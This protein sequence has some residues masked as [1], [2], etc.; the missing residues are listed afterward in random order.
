M[1]DHHVEDLVV[2]HKN[3]ARYLIENFMIAAN[4]TMVHFLGKHGVPHI[5]RIV[6]T[7][8]RWPRICQVAAQH[9]YSLPT[10]PDAP[11]L[12]E[13]LLQQKLKNP[14]QFPDIS[15]TIVKL[16]GR[17]EYVLAEPGKEKDGHF[18]L[19]VQDYTHSTAPNR[20]Y[21]DVIIQRLVKSVLLEE[22]TPYSKRELHVLAQWCTERDA[23]SKKVERFMR[24]VVAATLLQ[25]RIGEIFEGIIT[26]ASEKGT[27]VRLNHP[28]VEGRVTGYTEGLD[29][30]EHVLVRL[31]R[32][33]PEKGF[34]DFETQRPVP[35]INDPKAKGRRR[36]YYDQ[37][38]RHKD[39]REN[40]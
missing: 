13:F 11:A 17:G 35:M 28:P 39:H 16:I 25:G 38:N 29:V 10:E 23:A 18:G 4:M 12:M 33:V 40:F 22:K 37:R 34:I 36:R 3:R 26:G 24:K 21:I 5:Q 6:R 27:Y 8:E 14:E 30:G 2:K 31:V 15:L 19:A 1:K 9:G 32:M 20:R 7:P